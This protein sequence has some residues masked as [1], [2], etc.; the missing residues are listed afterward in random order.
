[1]KK[2]LVKGVTLE[3][4]TEIVTC[5]SCEWAKGHRKQVSK[6]R[7]DERRSTAVG[8]KIYSDLWGKATVESINQGKLYYIT[9]TDDF[10]RYMNVYFLHKKDK[11]LSLISIMRPDC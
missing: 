4:G 10:S 9:F 11:T 8:D 5:E 1:V 6:V 7:E 3:A 2:G